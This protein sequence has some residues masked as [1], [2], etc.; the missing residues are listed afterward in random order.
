MVCSCARL[1]LWQ[2]Q[3]DLLLDSLIIN[4]KQQPG[5]QAVAPQAAAYSYVHLWH[6]MNI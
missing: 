6:N 2:G 5:S 3:Q 1:S 4:N